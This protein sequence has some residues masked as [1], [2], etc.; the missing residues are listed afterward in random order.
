[1]AIMATPV[2]QEHPNQPFALIRNSAGCDTAPDHV[3]R[4]LAH[5]MTLIY[6][7]IL[8]GL[9][10]TYYHANQINSSKK[11]IQAFL[12]FNQC[13]CDII[14]FQLETVDKGIL[15]KSV[16]NDSDTLIQQQ[17][18]FEDLLYSYKDYI[19]ST[20]AEDF[21]GAKLCGHLDAFVPALRQYAVDVIAWILR[22]GES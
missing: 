6:N 3:G 1:M 9:N 17:E 13:L 22:Q 14:N 4:P 18:D 12:Q 15:F 16:K 21:D 2:L 20:K 5:T 11:S 19:Y 8:R 7:G 10:S